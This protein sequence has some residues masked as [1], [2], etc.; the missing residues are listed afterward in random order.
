MNISAVNLAF[1]LRFIIDLIKIL[2]HRIATSALF[3]HIKILVNLYA[4]FGSTGK[5]IE[6]HITGNQRLMTPT[7]IPDYPRGFTFPFSTKKG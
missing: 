5:N 3:D 2:G 7:I 1:Y 6:Y 4:P